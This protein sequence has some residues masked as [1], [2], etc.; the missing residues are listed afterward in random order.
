MSLCGRSTITRSG[1]QSKQRP[2]ALKR[3]A[4][5]DQLEAR[6]YESDESLPASPPR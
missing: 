3:C 5:C 6:H 2:E 1:G 4:R